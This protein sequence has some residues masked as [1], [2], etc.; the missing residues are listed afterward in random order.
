MTDFSHL[1]VHT[2]YSL[3]D[4]ACR[5]DKLVRR[6]REL[7]Q[8]ALAI[9]DHGAMYGI[10]EFFKAA[11]KEGI[12][13]IIGCEVYLAARRM[14]DKTYEKDYSRSHLILLAKN[15]EGYKNLMKIVSLAHTEGFYSKPRTD[16][17]TLLKYSKGLICLS[18]CIEGEIP[19]AILSND[20]DSARLMVSEYLTIFG[21][22]NFFLE[23]QDHGLAE[24]AKVNKAMAVL[25]KEFEVGLVA[26]NDVHYVDKRDALY[27]DVLLCIQTGK[28]IHD[29]DRMKFPG[30]EFYLKSTDE[31]ESLFKAFPEAISNTA[32]I[33]D[34]CNA[35][36]EFGKYHLPQF[37]LPEGTGHF[38]YLKT[39]CFDGLKKRY[40]SDY[41]GLE[42]RLKYELATINEMGFTDYFLIVWDF[43]KFAKERGIYVGPGRGS[44]AGSLVS[45]CLDITDIDPIKYDLL[46]ERFLNPQ[47]ITMPDIDID[48]DYERRSE[49]IDYVVQKYGQNRVAQIITFGTMKARQVVRDVGRALD[50]PYAEVDATAKM[51]PFDLNQTL[52]NAIKTNKAL[53]D[54]Y[55]TNATT[56]RLIDIAK[57]LEG[58]PR[59]ASTHAAGVVI[60]E[61]ELSDYVPL[62]LSDE[63]I[64][65]QFT[66]T[67][68]EE[69]GL[70]KMDFL[71]LR[72]LTIISNTINN[73][74]D[75]RIDISMIKEEPKVFEL[76]SSGNTDGV[77]Q[78]ESQGM[79]AFMQELR[80]KCL[81]D[82]I[83][84]I[85]LYRP[86][87]MDSIPTYIRNKNNPDLVKY[88]HPL[89]EP[90]LKVTYG[91]IVYQE[92]VMQI[93]QTLAGY[94]L[95]R[96]D[97]LRR[98]MSK[99]KSDAMERERQSFIFG[100]AEV[101][102]AVKRGVDQVT[103]SGI[104]DEMAEF[105][106]YAF[107]KSHAAAYA[108]IAYQTA[109]LK[110]FYPAEFMA[111]LMSTHL[112][113]TPKITQY[114][115]EM[116]KLGIRLVPPDIN[117]SGAD[118]TASGNNITFGL[119][120]IKNVGRSFVEQIKEER[121]KGPFKS[122][123]DFCTRMYDKG[124]N[125][126]AVESL[127]RAGA[128]DSLG[129]FRSQYLCIYERV[130]NETSSE[131]RTNLSG[132]ISLLG[133]GDFSDNL[134]DIAEF[135]RR[136]LLAM[137]KEVTGIYISGHPLDSYKEALLRNSSTTINEITASRD[138]EQNES[139]VADGQQVRIAG[140][141]TK[142]ITKFTKKDEEMAFI[143]IEDL[144][145]SI[146]VIVF[147]GLLSQFEQVLREDAVVSIIGRV[148]ARED[149]QPKIIMDGAYA[150]SNETL[151]YR[152]YIKIPAGY[153]GSLS[154]LTQ[155]LRIFSGDTPVYLYFEKDKKTVC[156]PKECNVTPGETLYGEI[157]KI[158]GDNCETVLK[159][160]NS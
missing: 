86:G 33:A 130:M 1:H 115:A 105:A 141:I 137:E 40:P 63:T 116:S 81:E 74:E 49:V 151:Q 99:K 100:D 50:I 104:F 20:M 18:A 85:S 51:I 149:E 45:Y 71:G 98:A 26:T 22:D 135:N 123:T 37:P 13:P 2:A 41:A 124:I 62:A 79:K 106:K 52:E 54:L 108:Q 128:F 160:I 96:A 57:E 27:Q 107:N 142:K 44:A 114:I 156:A 15:N 14:Y 132:Q 111:A 60:T 134:P 158:L 24:E 87:P 80:P 122:L 117:K 157:K 11:K 78:L 21:K 66:M 47:R 129:G 143:T 147:P 65:T 4:G 144:S 113:D 146:E 112:D 69:L 93:V 119:A 9:T 131:S 109:W 31:M 95:G 121:K 138:D 72:N 92:Q 97:I 42:K 103:A 56:R 110:T 19:K 28:T 75:K 17:Q 136:E 58:L 6:A 68:L 5:I 64:V 76:I 46:F 61:G 125:K 29:S 152:L 55:E 148:N 127:I 48:F 91:C 67:T 89:L 38:E 8:K 140:I 23:I 73:I 39:L 25:A 83:A 139:L 16:K 101:E 94:S 150:V 7:N 88:K 153:K 77:F 84:G 118:F 154:E 10:I 3:L 30:E 159:K 35:E 32:K 70:L 36:P 133:E 155:V 59:H 90:I 102:G 126:R 145:G 82:L 34:M 43:I 53:S 120:A 12:K